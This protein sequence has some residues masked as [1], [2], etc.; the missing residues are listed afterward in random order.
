MRCKAKTILRALCLP[1][2][3]PPEGETEVSGG[4]SIEQK[5]DHSVRLWYTERQMELTVNA[6]SLGVFQVH[7]EHPGPGLV[8]LSESK[9]D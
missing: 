9:L 5:E 6:K 8:F 3:G 2:Q 1:P 7:Q 4:M